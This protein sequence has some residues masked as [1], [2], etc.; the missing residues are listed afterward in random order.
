MYFILCS[1]GSQ[2]L[3]TGVLDVAVVTVF[4]EIRGGEKKGTQLEVVTVRQGIKMTWVG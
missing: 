1:W 4:G 3:N 2:V